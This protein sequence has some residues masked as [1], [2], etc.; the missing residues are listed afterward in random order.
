[1]SFVHTA[2]KNEI[3]KKIIIIIRGDAEHLNQYGR[4]GGLGEKMYRQEVAINVRGVVGGAVV[5]W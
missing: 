5:I 1:M 3:K 4:G 2:A